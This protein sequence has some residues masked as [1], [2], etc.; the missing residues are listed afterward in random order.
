MG[1]RQQHSQSPF[2]TP[3]SK[4]DATVCDGHPEEKKREFVIGLMMCGM[5]RRSLID[6]GGWGK[7][8]RIVSQSL[9]ESNH[10]YSE[11]N[12]ERVRCIFEVSSFFLSIA[13]VHL[14]N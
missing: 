14:C 5:K 3:E 2:H 9:F 10:A 12:E 11:F 8:I 1:V 7:L 13:I 4:E 6:G